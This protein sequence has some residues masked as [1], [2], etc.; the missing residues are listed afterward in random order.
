M[1]RILQFLDNLFNFSPENVLI[2]KARCFYYNNFEKANFK[3][4]FK[5]GYFK[6]VFSDGLSLKFYG[7]PFRDLL[8][9]L[10]GY[11][12]DYKIK[13]GDCVVDGGAYIGAFSI[14]IA[15]LLKD[16]IRVIAFEPDKFN[17]DKLLKNIELNNINNIIAINKGIW[18]KNEVLKFDNRKNKGSI[19]VKCANDEVKGEIMNYEFVKLDDE[20]K[21]LNINKVDF[22]KMDVEGAEIEAIEG[23]K[24]ILKTNNV[25]LA[26]ASYHIRNNEETYKKL[27]SMLNNLGYKTKTEFPEH[28]TTYGSKKY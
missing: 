10:R 3:I 5:N 20:L 11:L 15:K 7:N 12:K 2:N 25:N 13:E 16:N 9:P 19:M 24:N 21:K 22:I 23:C 6:I 26:I 28:L 4:Y 27:E 14:Y 1:K 17:F 8:H 18:N